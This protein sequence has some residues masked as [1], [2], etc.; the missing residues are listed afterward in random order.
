[1]FVNEVVCEI[2]L[3]IS[4]STDYEFSTAMYIFKALMWCVYYNHEIL[5]D[6]HRWEKYKRLVAYG[7]HSWQ[8]NWYLT[9]RRE[10]LFM[11]TLIASRLRPICSWFSFDPSSNS[12]LNATKSNQGFIILYQLK[13]IN[14][15]AHWKSGTRDPEVGPGTQDPQVGP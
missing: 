10:I 14:Y 1:M 2:V 13:Y 4:S 5:A 3:T 6:I 11:K 7:F 9:H 8:I 12:W 15:E